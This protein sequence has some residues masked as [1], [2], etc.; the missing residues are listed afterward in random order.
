MVGS[1]LID[2]AQFDAKGRQR[3]SEAGRKESRVG[4]VCREHSLLLFSQRL[5]ENSKD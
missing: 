4:L 1:A 2:G 3:K 5:I